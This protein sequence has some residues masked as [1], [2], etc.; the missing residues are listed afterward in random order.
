MKSKS[1]GGM[2]LEKIKWDSDIENNILME[3]APGRTRYNIEM[4]RIISQESMNVCTPY[5]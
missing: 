5:S 4:N 3:N 1:E 2:L